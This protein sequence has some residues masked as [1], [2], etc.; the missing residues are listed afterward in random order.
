MGPR[1]CVGAG[2][3]KNPADRVGMSYEGH[4][5]PV[6]RVERSPFMSKFFLTIGDWTWRLWNE[7]LR[8]PVITSK[9]HM[10]YL[11]DASW[12]PSRPGVFVTTKMDGT[13]PRR[14]GP[15]TPRLASPR[16]LVAG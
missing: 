3:A 15:S 10:S 4:A 14:S 11:T 16:R 12:S 5:G 1:D 6:Y 9:Y 2:K 7:E 13:V 8:G